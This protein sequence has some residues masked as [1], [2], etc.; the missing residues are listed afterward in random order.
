MQ[1]ENGGMQTPAV[2]DRFAKAQTVRMPHPRGCDKPVRAPRTDSGASAGPRWPPA[3]AEF[4]RIR[5]WR[6][7]EVSRLRLHGRPPLRDVRRLKPILQQN[8]V[9]RT[10]FAGA[11]LGTCARNSSG[12]QRYAR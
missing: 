9:P 5:S 3:V 8:G 1:G 10:A 2:R 11:E 12:A 6:Q 4:V 7:A